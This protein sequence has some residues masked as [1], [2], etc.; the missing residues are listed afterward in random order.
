[1]HILLFE[2]SKYSN[3]Y[4]LVYLRA[5]YN[6]KCGAF[7]N[8]E[9]VLK[10][11]KD[12]FPVSVHCRNELA[13]YMRDASTAVKVNE[14]IPDDYL[15]INGKAVCNSDALEFF[16]NPAGKDCVW[17]FGGEVVAANISAQN[18]SPI[19]EK[20][21]SASGDNT[22]ALNDFDIPGVTMRELSPED[23]N[24]NVFIVNYPWDIIKN[25]GAIIKEDLYGVIISTASLLMNIKGVH[26]IWDERKK[27][28]YYGKAVNIFPTVVLDS[29]DGDIVIDDYAVIEPFTFIKGPAYIGKHSVVKA[30]TRIYGPCVI[31][32][33]SKVAGEIS[34]SVFHSYVNKQH[35]GFVGNSY[36]CP[37]ANLGA[38][39]V[40]SNLK[41]NYS[42][43]K[44]NV[45]GESIDTGTRFVGSIIGDHS[46]FGV[47]TMLNTGTTAG[48]FANVFGGGFPPKIID[49]FSWNPIGEAPSKYDIEKALATARIVLERRS[50]T[51]TPHYEELIR[52]LFDTL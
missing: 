20:I 17:R 37:L 1:M 10:F 4:P 30:G 28:M 42:D 22:L 52:N 41:N 50:L 40:T 45:G 6:I 7:S 3:L 9:K 26:T 16:L 47:N 34:S 11:A 46:K 21:E 29:L 32:E 48:I 31:G 36:I 14:I 2:D 43:I 51:L 49:S 8:E 23:M 35:D 39:T 12:R 33:G 13:G 19:K 5:T 25:L 24:E 38:D 15:F 27:N 44:M 18:L